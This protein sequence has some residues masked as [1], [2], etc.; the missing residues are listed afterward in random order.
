MPKRNVLLAGGTGLTGRHLA[1]LLNEKGYAV[2]CLTRRKGYRNP[3][4][5]H[6]YLWDPA[7]KEIDELALRQA[8]AVINLSGAGP[9]DM[10][11]ELR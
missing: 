7:R 2:N 11:T 1:N 5:N 4:F 9:V 8:D 3:L 6:C 10:R